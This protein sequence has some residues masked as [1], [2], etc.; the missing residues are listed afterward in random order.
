MM[1]QGGWVYQTVLKEKGVEN[2]FDN[3]LRYLLSMLNRKYAKKIGSSIS[4]NIKLDS[5][6]DC[7]LVYNPQGFAK[8]PKLVLYIPGL[9]ET[10]C[11]DSPH[12]VMMAVIAKMLLEKDPEFE[13][14]ISVK[15]SQYIGLFEKETT[16]TE[17]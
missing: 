2:K 14:L 10:G 3:F 11:D 4:Q 15:V 5:W 13:A 7:A 9:H 12:F 17:G 8:H 6:S 1:E 16:Q